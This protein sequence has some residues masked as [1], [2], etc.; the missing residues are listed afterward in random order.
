MPDA[1]YF[2][3]RA[4]RCRELLKAARAPE[5]IEQLRVWASEFEAEARNTAQRQQHRRRSSSMLRQRTRA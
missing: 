3:G 5:V 2:A 1:T 4:E